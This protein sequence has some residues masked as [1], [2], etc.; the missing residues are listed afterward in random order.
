MIRQLFFAEF[1]LLELVDNMGNKVQVRYRGP[2]ILVDNGC[3][4]WSSTIAP[5]K[6][7]TSRK[8]YRWSEWIDSMQKDVERTFGIPKG[9]WRILMSGTQVHGHKAT[10]R[11]WK[12]CCALH[13]WLL[14]IDGLDEGWMQ[15]V[16]SPWEGVL[17]QFDAEDLE[18]IPERSIQNR[19][20]LYETN[21]KW[22]AGSP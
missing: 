3:L 2:W 9:R 4:N 1:E 18:L 21:G 8:E 12:T 6:K 7:T 22:R 13:N 14:D 16:P 5:F 11:V 17:E 19:L 10:D 15:G 20:Q